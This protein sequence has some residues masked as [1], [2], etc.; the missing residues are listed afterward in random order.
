[1][2]ITQLQHPQQELHID[3]IGGPDTP[4]QPHS[5]VN[6]MCAV[7]WEEAEG[8]NWYLG[9]VLEERSDMNYRIDHVECSPEFQNVFWKYPDVQIVS[10][11]QIL[12]RKIDG[13]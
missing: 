5:I 8:L 3:I 4:D 10:K 2:T 12:P 11:D 13:N 6:S 1:M 9:H 7:V